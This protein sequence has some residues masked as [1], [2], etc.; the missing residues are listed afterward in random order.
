MCE[1][2]AQ[3]GARN[4]ECIRGSWCRICR[5]WRAT[6]CMDAGRDRGTLSADQCYRRTQ[7]GPLQGCTTI[8]GRRSLRREWSDGMIVVDTSALIAILFGEPEADVFKNRIAGEPACLSAVSLQEASMVM[9]GR[10][11][12][13]TAWQELDDLI[14]DA[15]LE[16]IAH[17]LVLAEIARDAFIRFGKG[18]H[19]ARLNC[20]DCASYA[21]AR[22]RGLPLLFKGGDFA[23]TDIVPALDTPA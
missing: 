23:R 15:S 10:L 17:D 11:G 12:D 3:H 5:S 2:C 16:V 21:L 1:G 18:R 8:H 4:S 6:T 14:R 7:R 9:A 22:S 19:P 13:A 20:G